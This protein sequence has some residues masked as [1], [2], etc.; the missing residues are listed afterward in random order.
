MNYFIPKFHMYVDRAQWFANILHAGF[1]PKPPR[2]WIEAQEKEG[3]SPYTSAVIWN[4]NYKPERKF[5]IWDQAP[6]EDFREHG[7]LV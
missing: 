7:Y 4:R 1:N 6:D 2:W 3:R 5:I